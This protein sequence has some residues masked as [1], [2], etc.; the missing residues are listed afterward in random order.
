MIDYM[1]N[2]DKGN[3]THLAVWKS[4]VAASNTCGNLPIFKEVRDQYN[5]LRQMK[6]GAL[7]SLSDRQ[8]RR[9]ID[10]LSL[11]LRRSPKGPRPRASK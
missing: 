7:P 5:E 3:P 2:G 6:T 10:R 1:E 11:K 4:F 9:I 8:L